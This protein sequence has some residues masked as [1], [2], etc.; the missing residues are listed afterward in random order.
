MTDLEPARLL[1]KEGLPYS[2]KFQDCYFSAENGYAESLYVFMDHNNLPQRW[3]E[4]SSFT[5]AET[6]FGTGLNFL[7]TLHE[8]RK[9]KT[10]SQ[11]LTY[12]SI[13][14]HPL[15][16]T[17]LERALA[18]WPTLATEAEDLFQHYPPLEAGPH[19]CSLPDC[20]LILLF[21]DVAQQLQQITPPVD[22]WYLDGFAPAKN[23]KMWSS[24]G[25]EQL[26]Q[27]TAEQGT[28]STFTA[29]GFVR[30]GLQDV[31]FSVKKSKGFGRKREMLS[32][33][34]NIPDFLE[35]E[36]MDGETCRN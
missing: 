35:K 2:D 26:A 36:P 12:F 24:H 16:P 34:K 33:V 28:F 17:D 30:R 4:R 5:I 15:L 25:F 13:E 31:G 6:G 14:K 21:G 29:A 27:L 8:W 10:S 20:E 11:R 9:S 32:G 7:T 23:P 3:M 22:A 19:F 18:L 1:W